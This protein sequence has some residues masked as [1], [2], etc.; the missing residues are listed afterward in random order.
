MKNSMG[1]AC[2]TYGGRGEGDVYGVL[3]G[4]SEGNRTLRRLRW[5]IIL[6]WVFQK[7]DCGDH[8]LDWIWTGGG[9]SVVNAV[10]KL[11]VGEFLD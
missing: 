9:L 2:S 4:K 8:G 3:M 5:G 7:W 11:R 10:T 1:A 6:K